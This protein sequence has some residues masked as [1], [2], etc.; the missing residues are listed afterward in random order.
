[1]KI[2]PSCVATGR[3][4]MIL[5]GVRSPSVGDTSRTFLLQNWWKK[6]Q[7]VE[8]TEKYLEACGAE[9][10]FVRDHSKILSALPRVDGV[11]AEAADI[12]HEEAYYPED[13]W[14]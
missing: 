2:I 4:A 1:M 3:H 9:A 12:D 11:Y 14:Q 7:F 5:L 13:C 6:K 10:I 8:C